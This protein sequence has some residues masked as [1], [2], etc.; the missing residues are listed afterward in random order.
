[1][2]KKDLT[3]ASAIALATVMLI[4][5]C[6]GSAGPVDGNDSGDQ[7]LSVW[8]ME[9][10]I[11]EAT[12][13][14]ITDQF[15]EQ[16]GTTVKVELQQWDGINTKLITALATNDPPDVMQIGNTNV[17]LFAA[18][19]GLVDITQYKDDFYES[20][21]WLAGLAGPAVFDEKLFAVPLAG[22]SRA[23]MYDKGMWADAGID[24]PPTSFEE[25]ERALDLIKS[26]NSEPDFSPMYLAGVNWYVALSFLYDA[27]GSL[28]KQVDGKWVGQ[29]STP[30]SLKGLGQFVEFQNKYSSVASRTVPS[31]GPDSAVVFASG[32]ASSIIDSSGSL[33]TVLRTN[34]ELEGQVGSFAMPSQNNPGELMPAFMGGSDMG[35]AKNSTNKELGLEFLKFISSESVQAEIVAATGASPGSEAQLQA[36]LPTIDEFAQPFWDAAK[37]SISVPPTPGWATLESDGSPADFFSQLTRG[38]KSIESLA[39]T[40]DDHINEALNAS[41]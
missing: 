4:S 12:V 18:T 15:K 39:K 5:G 25:L 41:Y 13:T 29:L 36:L 2:K 11:P 8:L 16:T 10:E 23:V 32:R 20:D 6:G 9:G 40:F 3:T 31:G 26:Q 24:A 22:N 19:G 33:G 14:S 21:S 34:P 27:G 35:M 30:E 28:A 7:E 37:N 38:Q 1:M 17:P